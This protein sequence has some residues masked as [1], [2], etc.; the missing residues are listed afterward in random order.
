MD[1]ASNIGPRDS[2][3]EQFSSAAAE[4]IFA[5]KGL[6]ASAQ[7]K[8]RFLAK[9]KHISK[10]QMAR[11]LKDLSGR[12]ASLG[13][14]GRYEQVFMDHLSGQLT[15]DLTS[16]F[17]PAMRQTAIALAAHD[18]QIASARAQLLLD[19]VVAREGIPQISAA[20][21]KEKL[22]A[23]IVNEMAEGDRRESEIVSQ[24][25][26]AAQDFGIA[27]AD[28]RVMVAQE[29]TCH[30]RQQIRRWQLAASA[31]LVVV[32]LIGCFLFVVLSTSPPP[33]DGRETEVAKSTDSPTATTGDGVERKGRDEENNNDPNEVRPAVPSKLTI[34]QSAA[35]DDPIDLLDAFNVTN[36]I[37]NSDSVD[38]YER[39]HRRLIQLVGVPVEDRDAADPNS[40]SSFSDLK[41][42]RSVMSVLRSASSSDRETVEALKTLGSLAERLPDVTA[43]EG[44]LLSRFFFDRQSDEVKLGIESVIRRLGNWPRFLLAFSDAIRQ[45]DADRQWQQRLTFSLTAGRL[46]DQRLTDEANLWQAVFEMGILKLKEKRIAETIGGQGDETNLNL[47]RHALAF[48]GIEIKDIDDRNYFQRLIESRARNLGTLQRQIVIQQILIDAFGVSGNEKELRRTIDRHCDQINIAQTRG[49]QLKITQTTLATLSQLRLQGVKQRLTNNGSAVQQ[50]GLISFAAGRTLRDQAEAI[51]IAGNDADIDLAV[52]KYLAATDCENLG[53]VRSSLRGLIGVVAD[54]T[55]RKTFQRRIDFIDG[56]NFGPGKFAGRMSVSYSA[57]QLRTIMETC[58]AIRSGGAS[59]NPNRIFADGKGDLWKALGLLAVKPNDLSQREFEFV[60]ITEG[61]ASAA[62]RSGSN[63]IDPIDYPW[64]IESKLA[65]V[66]IVPLANWNVN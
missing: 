45:N 34:D 19:H 64:S 55:E 52:A 17:T 39:W 31:A 44:E 62:I 49:Q 65:P 46:K 36:A 20:D 58:R 8:I 59:N 13:R 56:G 27:D 42:K 24:L 60:V 33:T 6:T 38:E 1:D 5:E 54:E 40:G 37:S 29:I 47:E 10:K 4:I 7:Q 53:I 50:T 25:M 43:T 57:A 15:S 2:R 21:A 14:V 48:V 28:V 66:L 16:I 23:L 22:R 12:D 3:M 18:Y 63:K 32:I 30:R 41:R 51:V 26:P 11:C 61:Q 9:Q 35:E